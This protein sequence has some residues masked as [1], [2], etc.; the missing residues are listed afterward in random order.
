LAD[1]DGWIDINLKL[2]TFDLG[3]L[4]IAYAKQ[5]VD[6]SYRLEELS[7]WI[8]GYTTNF[9]AKNEYDPITKKVSWRDSDKNSYQNQ[10]YTRFINLYN[11]YM[12]ELKNRD[13]YINEFDYET[14]AKYQNVKSS[15]ML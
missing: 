15:V 10:Q 1:E 14:K 12:S 11:D 13:D 9:G 8:E 7:S 6:G 3:L 5:G 2:G 4:G